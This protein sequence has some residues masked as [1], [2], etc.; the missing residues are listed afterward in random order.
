MKFVQRTLSDSW[1]ESLPDTR[2][3]NR[4][5]G[6]FSFFPIVE[7]TDDRDLLGVGCPD[8][9]IGAACSVVL[10]RMCTQLVVQ[11]KVSPFIEEVQIILAEQRHAC[12]R[13]MWGKLDLGHSITP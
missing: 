7:V 1:Q 3:P 13:P 2:I 9:E 5:E 4:R 6:V 8:G 11:V 10:D 12:I